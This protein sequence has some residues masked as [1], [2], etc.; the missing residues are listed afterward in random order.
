MLV[1]YPSL[2][3]LADAFIGQKPNWKPIFKAF[4]TRPLDMS[5]GHKK[6]P[7]RGQAQ[8]GSD[9]R[10]ATA[11]GT[12]KIAQGKGRAKCTSCYQTQP[13]GSGKPFFV[14]VKGRNA[15]ALDRLIE[16]G[17]RGCTPI[18]QPAPRWS[19]YIH[20]LRELGVPIETLHEPHGGTYAGTHARYVL[21]GTVQKVT[22]P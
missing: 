18:E 20:R 12:P 2:Y 21:R 15:W 5:G 22:T 8:P 11:T 3:D 19:A 6:T 4:A 9:N 14:T 16:A 17:S 10:S 7:A 13:N 1:A